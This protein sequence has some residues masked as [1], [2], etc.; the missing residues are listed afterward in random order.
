MNLQTLSRL[1][2][3]SRQRRHL[4][5][6][7]GELVYKVDR[8]ERPPPTFWNE[9]E[10]LRRLSGRPH[11]PR[12]I[13]INAA[14]KA[15]VMTWCGRSLRSVPADSG[16]EVTNWQQQVDEILQSLE[17]VGI[18]HVDIAS[19][20]RNLTVDDAGVLHLIDFECARIG[21][22][23]VAAMRKQ[24]GYEAKHHWRVIMP[25]RFATYQ[26]LG[27]LTGS[28]DVVLRSN[29]YGL[30][31][32]T[33]P[34]VAM[35]D[36]GCNRGLFCVHLAGELRRAVGVDRYGHLIREARETAS[37]HGAGNCEFIEAAFRPGLL[38]ERFGLV[39]SLA[40]HDWL[41]RSGVS[42]DEYA[43]ELVRLLAPG[44]HLVV[45]T[46]PLGRRGGLKPECARLLELLAGDLERVAICSSE[47][48]ERRHVVRLRKAG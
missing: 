36:I 17:E 7:I 25:A 30:H 22:A 10:C 9:A 45:E 40:A 13:E 1:R 32:L 28:R 11:F 46:H 47:P 37:Q 39:L 35:L 29:L 43:A 19:G 27:T 34:D 26:G 14:L 8:R 4:L 18:T 5:Y 12:F 38:Q 44:G 15:V 31:E 42:T 6:R 41:R 16:I 33:G 20:G 24:F 21:P 23:N 48:G 2:P 3:F